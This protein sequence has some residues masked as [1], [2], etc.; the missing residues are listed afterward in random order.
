MYE[1]AYERKLDLETLLKDPEMRHEERRQISQK[2]RRI[3]EAL[4]E[5]D[6]AYGEDPLA[7]KWERE[8][9]E[10]KVPNLDEMP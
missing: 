5:T 3:Y 1:D 9:A 8:L 10:G 6:M 4:G 2:L 7:D